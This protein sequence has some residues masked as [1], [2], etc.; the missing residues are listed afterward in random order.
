[1]TKVTHT[2]FGLRAVIPEMERAFVLKDGIFEAILGPGRHNIGR[3]GNQARFDVR[4]FHLSADP[5][6]S[7][8]LTS[9][10]R[11][12]KAAASEHLTEV[13]TGA[14]EM[15]IVS[16]DG[17]PAFLVAP[18]S[19]K[20]VWTDAGLWSVE[21]VD[22]TDG[23]IMTDAMSRRLMTLRTDFIKRFK[24]EHGQVGLLHVDGKMTSELAP[25]GHAI[26][27][28]GKVITVKIVDTRETALDVTGQEILTKD[29]VSIRANLSATFKVVDPVLAVSAVKDFVDTLHRALGSAFRRSL[30][31]KTLDEVLAEKGAVDA[32]A[33][34]A[35]VTELAAAGVKVT[36]VTL[37]DIILPGEMREILNTVVLAEKEAE[38]GA[39]RRK[40]DAAETRALLNTAKVMADNPAMMRLK[41]LEALEA[42]SD[43]VGTLTVHSGT[44]GLMEDL[45]SLS[46]R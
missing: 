42:I 19:R 15:A 31:T 28:F 26:W 24:V 36:H 38:A 33:M 8:L 11:N 23:F 18:L 3:L 20:V 14:D 12:H 2:I 22:L 32:E 10:L 35:V 29:R 6:H 21:R 39:I 16:L 46:S 43:K 27:S 1:M 25:G 17:A 4:A 41:E 9:V 13:E 7:E 34:A 5:I 44:K 45:V 37:K 40:E 30:A